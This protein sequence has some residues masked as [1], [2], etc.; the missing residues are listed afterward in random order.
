MFSHSYYFERVKLTV[1]TWT[2][3]VPLAAG[4]HPLLVVMNHHRPPEQIRR[5]L[6]QQLKTV[7][8]TCLIVKRLLTFRE[9][10]Q[11]QVC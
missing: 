10:R 7:P 8:R 11:L 6:I 5:F 2:A 9:L 4:N 3:I 1:A